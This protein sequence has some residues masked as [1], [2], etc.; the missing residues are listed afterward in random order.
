MN[1]PAG[2]IQVGDRVTVPGGRTGRVTKERLLV[3][4]GSWFCTVELD[5]GGTVEVLDYELKKSAA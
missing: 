2:R 1:P 5:G 4:N 3:S